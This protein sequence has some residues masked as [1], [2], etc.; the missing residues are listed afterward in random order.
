MLSDQPNPIQDASKEQSFHDGFKT[1]GI[2]PDSTRAEKRRFELAE[3]KGV[4]ERHL[5][6]YPFDKAENYK[7]FF[8]ATHALIRDPLGQEAQAKAYRALEQVAFYHMDSLSYI[9]EKLEAAPRG[10][11]SSRAVVHFV[12]WVELYVAGFSEKDLKIVSLQTRQQLHHASVLHDFCVTLYRTLKSTLKIGS[13]VA[14]SLAFAA[15][16]AARMGRDVTIADGF[17]EPA[18]DHAPVTVAVYVSLQACVQTISA[19]LDTRTQLR[20]RVDTFKRSAEAF[21]ALLGLTPEQLAREPKEVHEELLKAL[22]PPPAKTSET[23]SDDEDSDYGGSSS[24]YSSVN[25][26]HAAQAAD[27]AAREHSAPEPEEDRWWENDYGSSTSYD[28]NPANGYLMIDGIG[29]VDVMGNT[30]GFDN[31]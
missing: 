28:V 1:F 26:Y 2:A 27:Q 8:D 10:F 9:R 18:Y 14:F 15:Q 3:C 19:V 29:G 20:E 11:S 21:V 6:R 23:P 24:G 5:K 4:I 13:P 31:F 25:S 30:Y 7:E 22:E 12:Y 17:E 16:Q